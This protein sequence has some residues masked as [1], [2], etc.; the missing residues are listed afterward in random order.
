MLH[1]FSLGLALSVLW[2]L[3]SGYFEVLIL[4]MGFSSVVIILWITYCMDIIDQENHPIHFTVRSFRFLPWLI[5][6]IVLANIKVARTIISRKIKLTTSVLK[7]RS[8]QATE[9]GQV[10]YGNSITL[11]P[12]T[13]T[14]GIEKD[15]IT[16]HALT[17]DAAFDLKSGE[18]DRQITNIEP[19]PD[20]L[21]PL[22]Q[23]SD[24]QIK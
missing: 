12:G 22:V 24:G 8:S 7:V 9:V 4:T 14:I 21:D 3:L 20:S 11:T 19:K 17:H 2:L 5:K 16:V 10:I 23:F 15:I 1:L 13:V 18:M 6:E